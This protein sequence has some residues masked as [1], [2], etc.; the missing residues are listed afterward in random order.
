PPKPHAVPPY[1]DAA[2]CS[3]TNQEVTMNDSPKQK[4]TLDEIRKMPIEEL[5]K[6]DIEILRDLEDQA[7]KAVFSAG[8]ALDWVRGIIAKKLHDPAN[9]NA[10]S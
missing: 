1:R 6:L 4:L 5:L 8:L 9:D 7:D 10:G 2:S 3:N